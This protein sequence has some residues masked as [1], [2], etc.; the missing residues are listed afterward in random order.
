[1]VIKMRYVK[2]SISTM[3]W[4][5]MISSNLGGQT[6]NA[7]V[8][9]TRI[10]IGE[11]VTFKIE[12]V[13][14]DDMPDVDISPILKYFDL[15]SGPGQQTNIQWVNGRMTSS[16]V[17]SWT[18][19]PKKSGTLSIPRLSVKLGKKTYLT[20]SVTIH[21]GKGVQGRDAEIFIRAELDKETAY[22]GEQ[23]TVTYKLYRSVNFSP[24]P[25]NLPDFV[26]FW[27]EV[28]YT[29]QSLKFRNVSLNGKSYQAADL[30]KVAL[31]PTKTGQLT[32]PSLSVQGQMEKKTNRRSR[33]SPVFDPFFDSF[34]T[35][36]VA[37]H[38]RSPE[39][40]ITIKQYPAKKPFDYSGAVG[41]FILSAT[42]DDDSVK[43]NEGFTYS[44][45]LKGTGNMGQFSLPEIQ[46]PENVEA[47]PP[48]ESLKK[49][50]FRD[51]LTGTMSWEYI[52]IPR[53][54]GHLTIPRIQMP[55]FDVESGS[56]KR[57]QT[58]PIELSI[59][60]AD[61][62]SVSR[63]NRSES[64]MKHKIK[65]RSYPLND[66]IIALDISSSMLA[67]DFSPNRLEA[68]KNIISNFIT[69]DINA[70]IGLLAFAGESFIECPITYNHY[71]L[72]RII[73][74]IDIA[75]IET[76]GT[77]IGTAI[78]NAIYQI[79]SSDAKKKSVILITDG[80]SNAGEIDPRTA[81]ELAATHNIKIYTIGTG[82]DKST[83][84]IPGRGL[85]RN[86]I[87]ESTLSYIA[88][89]T[90][91]RYFRAKDLQTL[92]S[93]FSEIDT[94]YLRK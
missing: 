73:E 8:D 52:L 75:K 64:S 39:K 40:K 5:F 66:I 70:R 3:I 49:D 62:K 9:A 91:G 79:K 31:F 18:F 43:V 85:I 61:N 80:N 30:Y 19:L 11:T 15:V 65:T 69:G 10:T 28:V 21:V 88:E 77:A 1:M 92:E 74:K 48:K 87:D 26:G 72:R 33:R 59:L 67:D 83:I 27:S 12:A 90:G 45:R 23:M 93:I 36:T 34:F 4:A 42:V 78:C 22:V 13:D 41:S 63:D 16:R 81:A 14:S 76:D 84:Q 50:P 17:L 38:I 32:I 46:F 60:A 7:T 86:E 51:A 44:V 54:A 25:Y 71:V 68:S 55:Y 24:S 53:M 6:I 47:F 56:W 82:T 57:A 20:T 58:T 37:K 29:P 89:K 2:W 94:S 35:E